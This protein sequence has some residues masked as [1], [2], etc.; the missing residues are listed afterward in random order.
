MDTNKTVFF[1][2]LVSSPVAKLAKEVGGEYI[3]IQF[4]PY[5]QT[6]KG[7]LNYNCHKTINAVN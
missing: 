2:P 3:T 7:I 4:E 1:L 6:R 5:K